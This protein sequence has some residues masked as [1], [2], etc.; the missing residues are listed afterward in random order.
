MEIH[1]EFLR[2]L[3]VC[4]QTQARVLLQN[5]TN[6]QVNA[7]SEICYNIL[8]GED[9]DPEL[10]SRLKKHSILIRK[11]GDR[12]RG[13]LTRREDIALHP[14]IVWKVLLLFESHI[15]I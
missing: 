9:I 1:S 12:S 10:L 8:H 14:R 11:I 6:G 3:L 13:V 7:I 5:T 15:P 2:F 4:T